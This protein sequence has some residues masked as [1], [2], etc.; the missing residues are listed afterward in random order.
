MHCHKKTNMKMSAYLTRDLSLDGPTQVVESKR[1]FAQALLH[2]YDAI[3]I[4]KP[5]GHIY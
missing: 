1:S 3:I 2:T 5:A 4:T